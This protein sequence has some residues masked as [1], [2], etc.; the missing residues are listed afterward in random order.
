MIEASPHAPGR[1]FVAARNN[2]LGDRQPYLYKTDDYGATWTRIDA[3]LPR[4][5][6]THVIRE[7]PARRGLLYAGT[8]HGVY[9]SFDD[10]ARWQ[11]LSLNLPDVQVPDLKVERN[12]LVIST[13]GRSFWVL[14]SIAMLRQWT[15][16]P[17]GTAFQLFKPEGVYRSAR[18]ARIDLVAAAP[19]TGVA[20]EILDHDG[21]VLR[22]IDAPK[23]L[24]AGHHR[25]TWNLRTGGATVFPGIVLEAPSPTRGVR[26]PPGEYQVRVRANGVSTART[27]TVQ[28]DPRA[29]D[30]TPADY[31]AQYA[32]ARRLRDATSAADE[33]VLRIR[34]AK[35]KLGS[36]PQQAQTIAELSAIEAEL[37]Q[38][39]NRTPKDKIAFPIRLND[40]LAGLLAIVEMGD[41]APTAADRAVADEL[42]AELDA[43][44]ARL[45]KVLGASGASGAGHAAR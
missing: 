36:E 7:D 6:F 10:G 17:P 37:Y 44:L 5:D 29:A 20:V 21:A 35:A 42:I 34:D 13:H 23:T 25:L 39:K 45:D 8:E 2:Q 43:H 22:A 18:P 11:S 32:L 3:T 16:V 19:L 30:V 4:G 1:A 14:S 27:F 41:D 31:A 9:V 24:G 40:R 33:A 15:P 28:A 12:D 38:V 26:V